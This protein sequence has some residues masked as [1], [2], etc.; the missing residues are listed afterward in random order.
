M[1]KLEVS[2]MGRLELPTGTRDKYI[3]LAKYKQRSYYWIL[4]LG[5]CLLF[6]LSIFI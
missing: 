4:F 6:L 2:D 3:A 5:G 1:P